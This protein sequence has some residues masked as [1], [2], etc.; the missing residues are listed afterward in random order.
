M[1]NTLLKNFINKPYKYGFNTNIKTEKI[2]K[3][4][5]TRN[6]SFNFRKK[7]RTQVYS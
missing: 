1:V 5:N 4:L 2:K 3:G 6:Y 7:K